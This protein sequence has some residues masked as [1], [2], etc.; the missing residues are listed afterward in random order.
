VKPDPQKFDCVKDFPIP[1]N[2]KVVK[3]FLGLSGYYRRFI[4][5]H[6]QI[7][8]PLK[9]LLKKHFPY[10]WNDLC[11]H[12]F[13]ILKEFLI[14]F[15]ILQYPDF[16]KPFDLTCDARNFSI[17]CVLSQ[18]PIGKGLPIAFAS[19][20]LN[21]EEMNYHTIEKE[22]TSIVWGIELFRPFLD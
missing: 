18:A 3:S 11:Q 9:A 19:R 16:I 20:M 2:L 13:Q 1:K 17:G 7:A 21:K 22:L 4:K 5:N 6:G 15:K 14:T 8:K 10:I 12:S